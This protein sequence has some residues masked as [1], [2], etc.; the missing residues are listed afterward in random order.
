MS[1]PRRRWYIRKGNNLITWHFCSTNVVVV[2]KPTKVG[3][4]SPPGAVKLF[5][6]LVWLIWAVISDGV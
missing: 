3:V 4:K 1:P 2:S 6:E 5:N